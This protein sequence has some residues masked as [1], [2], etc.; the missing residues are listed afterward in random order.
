MTGRRPALPLPSG[1]EQALTPW[2]LGRLT[3]TRQLPPVLV[4]A[5]SPV[6][7][8]SCGMPYALGLNCADSPALPLCATAAPPHAHAPTALGDSSA[9]HRPPLRDQAAVPPPLSGRAQQQI[10]HTGSPARRAVTLGAGLG[11]PGEW[12]A[13]DSSAPTCDDGQAHHPHQFSRD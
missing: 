10:A 2:T 13:P 12:R 4:G 9:R 11:M 5:C 8:V 3:W 7:W 6:I 1:H